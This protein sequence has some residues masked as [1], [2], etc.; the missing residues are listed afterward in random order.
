M[1]RREFLGTVS[2]AALAGCTSGRAVS[3]DG[4]QGAARSTADGR[5]SRPATAADGRV[6]RPARPPRFHVFS[7]MFQP[8]VTKSPE[9]LCELMAAAGYDGIQ[10]TVRK[11]GHATPE[12]AATEL[13]R[14]VKIAASF[15]LKCESICTGITGADAMNCVPP[16]G[17]AVSMKPPTAA[18]SMPPYHAETILKAA[19]DCGIRQFRTG[20][21]FYDEKKETFAQSME[22]F[23]RSFA[24][25]AALGERCGIKATYQNHSSWG[26]SVFG[27]LVWD[28]YEC[29]KDIDPALVGVEYDPMHAYF[30]TNLS[31][32]HG[33]ELIAPWIS[34]VDLK[35]FHYRL[36]PKNSKM[37]KKAMVAA[38]EGVVPWR[39]TKRLLD[40]HGVDPLYIV[41]FEYD[42]DKTNLQKTVKDELT[43]FKRLLF[44]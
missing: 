27:G 14:L 6:A 7:K 33:L 2:A 42:F 26:P 20:Y 21:F 40:R 25:L 19:A 23:K 4:R 31:W 15:G 3:T 32:T 5:A 41:H 18:S 17:R 28:V 36:D 44:A 10:W 34:S 1:N 8:P 35:D 11:G 43:V 30:E 12:N 9:A 13:P 22:R 16:A 29:V 38:G 39:E 37:M 24:A